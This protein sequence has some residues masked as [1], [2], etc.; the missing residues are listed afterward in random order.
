[1]SYK[2]FR[3]IQA[4]TAGIIGMVTA[5]SIVASSWIPPIIVIFLGMAVLFISKRR[6]KEI[7][8][9]ERTYSIAEKA[10]RVTLTI[11]IIGMA[12]AGVI[13]VAIYHTEDTSLANTGYALE[14]GACALMIV[15]S[16]AYNYYSRKLGGR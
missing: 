8:A 5:V 2:T 1:M 12:V 4:I 6:V 7:M 11:G 9:D 13:L 10:A 14:Y 16:F 3:M 15:N